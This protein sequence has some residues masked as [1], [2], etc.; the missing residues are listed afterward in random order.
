[1]AQVIPTPQGETLQQS[2]HPPSFHARAAETESV[3]AGQH[4][5]R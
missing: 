1:M 2:A 5:H 4:G 3:F